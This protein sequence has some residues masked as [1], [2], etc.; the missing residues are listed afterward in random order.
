MSCERSKFHERL[1]INSEHE[2][3]IR[4]LGRDEV[5]YNFFPIGGGLFG[6]RVETAASDWK[7]DEYNP[8]V[9]LYRLSPDGFH[10]VKGKRFPYSEDPSV[11]TIRIPD[12]NTL[13]HKALFLTYVSPDNFP[14]TV[15]TRMYLSQDPNDINPNQPTAEIDGIKDTYCAQQKDGQVLWLSRPITE[16]NPGSIGIS[17]MPDPRDITDG[18]KVREA[19]QEANNH[20]LRFKLPELDEP[21]PIKVGSKQAIPFTATLP[22]GTTKEFLYVLCH[23]AT[24][25]DNQGYSST[26]DRFEYG[27]ITYRAYDCVV[28]IDAALNGKLPDG[29][30]IPLEELVTRGK[31]A[32][33]S[34]E[35]SK[36]ERYKQVI[37]PTGIDS[38]SRVWIGVEDAAMTYIELPP[39]RVEFL[40]SNYLQEANQQTVNETD[41][42]HDFPVRLQACVG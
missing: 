6:G 30:E 22:D 7:N 29:F 12:G 15:S 37:F 25:A 17:R 41:I 38:D 11:T 16:D 39:N 14:R 18:E 3:P 36:G 27:D 23:V 1:T 19:I 10:P 9:R 13:E 32:C 35:P 40:I 8:E 5:G 24:A 21:G 31:I 28:D 4:G 42:Q 33:G 34:P 20:I 26:A 2:V